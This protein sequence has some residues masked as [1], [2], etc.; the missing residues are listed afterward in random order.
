MKYRCQICERDIDD[1]ASITHIKS[2]EYLL[3]LIQ[4]DHPE[5]S[6]EEKTCHQC[7]EYYRKMVKDAE[8]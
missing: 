5:W 8:I 6:H 7:L 4:K 2:E 1:F 3:Q